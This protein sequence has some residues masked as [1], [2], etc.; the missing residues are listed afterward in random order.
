MNDLLE[1][2][3][4]VIKT[5]KERMQQYNQA[6]RQSEALTR[7]ALIDPLLRAL[8]WDTADP[9][10]VRPEYPV[11]RGQ[12][13]YALLDP[14][15]KVSAFVEAKSLGRSLEQD[16]DIDQLVRY[17]FTD[18]IPYAVLTNGNNWHVYDLTIPGV[19]IKDRRM[20]EVSISDTSAH[21]AALQMLLLWKPNLAGE[22]QP[23]VANFPL[24]GL[25]LEP[26]LGDSD[27]QELGRTP[28]LAK[29]ESVSLAVVQPNQRE[30]PPVLVTLP[31]G[32]QRP[33]SNWRG[34]LIQS[35]EWLVETGRLSSA[36]FPM[37]DARGWGFINTV[38]QSPNGTAF[39]ASR[40]I[41][42]GIYLNLH[43]SKENTIKLA[44]RLIQRFG[45]SPDGV[46]LSFE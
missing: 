12:A 22:V 24:V 28:S 42:G 17:A 32:Q 43:W 14:T 8:G 30:N 7:Y 46:E 19:A 4:S 44:T 11:S 40:L 6:L 5:V 41:S 18:G 34:V 2:L 27:S 35:A 36:D 29:L 38:P 20:L 26:P 23:A 31:D 3:V 39:R 15:G 10:L 45:V 25:T 21:P 1:P 33:I 9:A 13:D 37:S 16:Q